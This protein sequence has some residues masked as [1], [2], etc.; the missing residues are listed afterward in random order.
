MASNAQRKI[1]SAGQL[2]LALVLAFAMYQFGIARN[3]GSVP[4]WLDTV[5]SLIFI[6]GVPT[7]IL[8]QARHSEQVRVGSLSREEVVLQP[9]EDIVFKSSFMSGQFFLTGMAFNPD[10]GFGEWLKG[11]PV[12]VIGLLRVRLTNRSLVFGLL[13]GRTWRVL[14]L[15]AIREVRSIKGRWP[16]KDALLVEYE[17]SNRLEKILFWTGSDRGNRL[18]AAL[19]NAVSRRVAQ[20][21]RCSRPGE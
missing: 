14:D 4:N 2:L 6:V 21:S 1:A 20:V 13:V 8:L 9:G 17:F 15:S 16:Y 11:G 3:R 18:K 5:V 10:L 19:E 12:R 7:G